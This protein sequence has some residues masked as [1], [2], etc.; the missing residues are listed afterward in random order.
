VC[1]AAP[2]VTQCLHWQQLR[3]PPTPLIYLLLL[4]PPWQAIATVT[5]LCCVAKPLGSCGCSIAEVL[6]LAAR[7]AAAHDHV[8]QLPHW[9]CSCMAG[10]AM[11]LA[12]HVLSCD[13]QELSLYC[14]MACML[15]QHTLPLQ[16][17]AAQ[18][19]SPHVARSARAALAMMAVAVSACAHA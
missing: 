19:G 8:T 7:A 13:Q 12:W 2:I 15:P 1:P 16:S 17:L 5:C 14:R 10:S 6:L 3:T 4:L 11:L 9:A 18:H